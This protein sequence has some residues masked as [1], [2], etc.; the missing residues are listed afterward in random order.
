MVPLCS[1]EEVLA[2]LAPLALLLIQDRVAEV[3]RSAALVTASLLVHL[4]KAGEQGV[5]GL[6]RVLVTVLAAASH[7]AR[8]QTFVYLCGALL[9]QETGQQGNTL[10]EGLLPSL[11]ALNVDPVPNVRLALAAVLH[12]Q[13][14]KL[15]GGKAIVERYAFYD[16]CC[17]D[18]LY[19][20]I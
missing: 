16:A 6:V 2:H 20:Q 18:V 17:I 8:R 4:A 3:R 7:W 19:F 12:C 11:L 14:D 13:G 15:E 10:M 9:C 5:T 1:P